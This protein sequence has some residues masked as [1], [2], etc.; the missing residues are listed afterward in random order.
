MK[1]N[2]PNNIDT[3][4]LEAAGLIPKET[5]ERSSQ[6][7]QKFEA[8]P[9]ADSKVMDETPHEV[10]P[11]Y[12]NQLSGDHLSAAESKKAFEQDRRDLEDQKARIS[13]QLELLRKQGGDDSKFTIPTE[14]FSGT[15]RKDLQELSYEIAAQTK[16][17]ASS[18]YQKLLKSAEISDLLAKYN[19]AKSA[20]DK[21]SRNS[22]VDPLKTLHENQ[23]FLGRTKNALFGNTKRMENGQRLSEDEEKRWKELEDAINERVKEAGMNLFIT[24][25][26]EI[27]P[28]LTPLN[29]YAIREL[30]KREVGVQI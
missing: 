25:G 16:E 10:I 14:V 19:E 24:N 28:N 30:F 6:L 17:N 20:A 29:M 22:G 21:Q 13:K 9:E 26:N 18:F 7:A 11:Q 4:T 23:G 3:S 5:V 27:V 1:E 8:V 12:R 2:A 15:L